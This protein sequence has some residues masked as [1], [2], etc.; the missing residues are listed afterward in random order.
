MSNSLLE[1]QSYSKRLKFIS[2]DDEE[3]IISFNI[4][5]SCNHEVDKNILL[6]IE[7]KIN[8]M[9]LTNYIKYEDYEKI[10]QME[11][12]QEKLK[13]ENDKLQKKI[14]SEQQKQLNQQRKYEE[15]MKKQTV[16]Q[17]IKQEEKPNKNKIRIRHLV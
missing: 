10:K 3:K 9:I 8:E 15:Q 1:N 13:K 12:E 17:E 7:K 5:L 6:E 4:G 14:I 11:K 2:N 16:K